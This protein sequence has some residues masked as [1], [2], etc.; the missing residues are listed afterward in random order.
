MI[1]RNKI[2]EEIKQ[3]FANSQC[4]L[5]YNNRHRK[6]NRWYDFFIGITAAIGALGYLI[7]AIWPLVSTFLISVVS[8]S[9]P[10]FPS[11]LQKEEELSSLDGISDFY[12]LYLTRLEEI[13]YCLDNKQ[14]SEQEVAK[15]FFKLK[16]DECEK[17]SR[18]NK[19]IRSISKSEQKFLDKLADD[20]TNK[21]YFNKYNNE[22]NGN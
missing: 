15:K 5:R 7:D 16:E 3:A 10:L 22:T 13:F 18:M 14:L 8:F 11:I 17:Q 19:L 21:I 12:T 9:K 1:L 6:W 4:I 2:W 20:Y